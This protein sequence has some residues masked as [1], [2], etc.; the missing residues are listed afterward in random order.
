M[1]PDETFIA[2]L[3]DLYRKDIHKVV[4]GIGVP[5]LEEQRN[6][7]YRLWELFSL[8]FGRMRFHPRI[9]A[10]S[11]RRP[12]GALA[13]LLEPAV[14]IPGGAMSLRG[15]VAR[16]ERFD[17]TMGPYALG[18]DREFS[19]RIGR[20]EP[21]FNAR[22]LRIKHSPGP[23]GRGSWLQRGRLYVVN[24]LHIVQTSVEPGPG[25]QL[26]VYI[27]FTS[28][29]V[30]HLLWGLLTAGMHNVLFAAGMAKELF[31]TCLARAGRLLCE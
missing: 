25:T 30:Q 10:S 26:L 29:L 8:V 18:E 5:Y 4:S 17:E 20:T 31:S 12:G 19:Y 11:Y 23:G 15:E 21:L 3:V 13:G 2:G 7:K 27:D 16:R 6:W 14:M 9:R 1:V 24:M 22:K 28:A